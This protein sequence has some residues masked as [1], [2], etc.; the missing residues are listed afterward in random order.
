MARIS[1]ISPCF[2]EED[3]VESCHAA[4]AKLFAYN[5]PLARYVR[6]HIFADNASEDRTVGI[7]GAGRP[8]P[9]SRLS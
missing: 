6:E 3:N 5:G 9:A 2:N 1:I 7:P 8:I 4:V